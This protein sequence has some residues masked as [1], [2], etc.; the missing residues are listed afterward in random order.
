MSEDILNECFS[1]AWGIACRDGTVDSAFWAHVRLLAERCRTDDDWQSLLAVLLQIS[2]SDRPAPLDREPIYRW[3]VGRLPSSGLRASR[4]RRRRAGE[5]SSTVEKAAR[6]A[7]LTG[8]R[9]AKRARLRA[10]L[11]GAPDAASNEL[12]LLARWVLEDAEAQDAKRGEERELLAEEMQ[13]AMR[14]L[15]G[16]A[17]A[18]KAETEQLRLELSKVKATADAPE[19]EEGM[20]EDVLRAAAG[21]GAAVE[22]VEGGSGG[23]GAA[24]GAPSAGGEAKEAAPKK[25][26]KQTLL[27]RV[28]ASAAEGA[29]PDLPALSELLRSEHEDVAIKAALATAAVCARDGDLQQQLADVGGLPRIVSLLDGEYSSR[30]LLDLTLC[31]K[32]LTANRMHHPSL[33][34]QFVQA[35]G[36]KK[37]VRLASGPPSDVVIAALQ[38][39]RSLADAPNV[40]TALVNENCLPPLIRCLRP[41]MPAA[42]VEP[43]SAAVAILTRFEGACCPALLNAQGIPPLVQLISR[44]ADSLAAHSAASS[45]ACLAAHPEV[46]PDA[47]RRARDAGALEALLPLLDG[48]LGGNG[49]QAATAEAV[50]H[51]LHQ[52]CRGASAMASELR[53]LGGLQSL[54]GLLSAPAAPPL[55]RVAA[56]GALG[57]CIGSDS[58]ACDD[59][60]RQGTIPLLAQLITGGTKAVAEAAHAVLALLQ[61]RGDESV[62]IEVANAMAS[63]SEE[64]AP[65]LVRQLVQGNKLARRA[66][67]LLD[68]LAQESPA[69]KTQIIKLGAVPKLVKMARG[70]AHDLGTLNALG[71][72][73]VLAQG[74]VAVQD[75]ARE[76]GIFPLL[77]PLLR[78]SAPAPAAAPDAASSDEEPPPTGAPEG[79]PTSE[80]GDAPPP[81]KPDGNELRMN[82]ALCLIALT[83]S[84]KVSQEAAKKVGAVE[85]VATLL[86][87]DHEW[88]GA[89]LAA[90]A[91]QVRSPP[92]LHVCMNTFHDLL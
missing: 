40:R 35:G 14:K 53:S 46:G 37:L 23:G 66:A 61:Q 6:Q 79:A 10:V 3:T 31:V 44:G 24:G 8:D 71:A 45:L 13:F 60:R 70:G 16:A 50:C 43:A 42:A 68:T 77:I 72:L 54:N 47:Q 38:I 78:P 12:P 89:Y 92:Y 11:D 80:T 49:S 18:C 27:Q 57:S 51:A 29:A 36:P 20:A 41:S 90:M 74:T 33:L 64:G 25:E 30:G 59:L 19:F 22:G 9:K 21:G 56:C 91:M 82:A 65:S 28:D 85:A 76:A 17:K 83:K 73:E 26:T 15:V 86:D 5:G 34:T 58:G 4:P 32:A 69:A 2:L 1:V 62:A 67:L 7:V 55:L 84:N 39:I 63:A 48:V 88:Q 81:T 87:G 75:E 52:L